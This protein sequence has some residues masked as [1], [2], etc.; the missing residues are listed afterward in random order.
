[1][2]ISIDSN[3]SCLTFILDK[4]FTDNYCLTNLTGKL[5]VSAK[6]WINLH[7]RIKPTS[8][9]SK[10]RQSNSPS[11]ESKQLLTDENISF[12]LP[13]EHSSKL[14]VGIDKN[15]ILSKYQA[16]CIEKGIL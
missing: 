9:P 13:K 15:S 11:K 7:D 8:K 6:P 14:S 4:I 3:M 1:M 5:D 16:S 10:I 2:R 12:A